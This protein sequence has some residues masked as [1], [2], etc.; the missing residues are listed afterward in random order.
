MECNFSG[1]RKA[2]TKLDRF[3]FVASWSATVIEGK[4]LKLGK[5]K[6]EADDED[7]DA[8]SEEF[9]TRILLNGFNPVS[10]TL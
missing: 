8:D 4:Y 10:N 9:E 3:E 6:A 2:W 1:R 7:E 5:R